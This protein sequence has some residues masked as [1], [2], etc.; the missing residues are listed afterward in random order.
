MNGNWMDYAGKWVKGAKRLS[1]SVWGNDAI[2]FVVQ[3]AGCQ[4]RAA[5]HPHAH[6]T[7]ASRRCARCHRAQEDATPR[8][9]GSLAAGPHTSGARV[10]STRALA[11][12]P[13]PCPRRGAS[14]P[15]MCRGHSENGTWHDGGVKK[16]HNA[17]LEAYTFGDDQVLNALGLRHLSM[18]T[19]LVR[20][21]VGSELHQRHQRMTRCLP[22]ALVAPPPSSRA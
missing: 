5:A 18:E 6:S 16:C 7:T 3:Y 11:S 9:L 20:A 2:P 1:Q 13:R 22:Y 15:Q 14:V 12:S 21:N 10:S 4:V 8:V 19:H 17:F